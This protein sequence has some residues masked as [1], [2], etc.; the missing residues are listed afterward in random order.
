MWDRMVGAFR[1]HSVVLLGVMALF[2]VPQVYQ[3]LALCTLLGWPMLMFN[4]LHDR[5]HIE[6][7]WMTR[8]PV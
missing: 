6:N 8:V 5:M 2:G 1:D 3:A 4:Y 7:F